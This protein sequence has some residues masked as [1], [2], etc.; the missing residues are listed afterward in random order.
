MEENYKLEK[1]YSISFDLFRDAY[2][3]FQKKN[4]YPKSYLFMGVFL[5]VAIIYIFAAVKDPSNKLT[6]VL[7]FLCLALA[8]REWYN[9]RKIKRS[10]TDVVKEMSEDRYKFCL[11]DSYVDIS[12]VHIGGVENFADKESD[13]DEN[14]ESAEEEIES[15]YPEKTRI[16]L[17]SELS[18]QEYEKYFLFYIKKKTFYIVPKD[19]FS[20]YEL[21]T[22]REIMQIS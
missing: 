18:I 10:V 19:D 3:T 6:Y 16:P 22:V 17:N 15:E 5:L 14:S 9:P 11:G 13:S 4:I 21:E 8:F 20:E 1:E 7:I 12:T 2:S